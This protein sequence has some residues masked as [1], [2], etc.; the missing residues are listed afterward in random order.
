VRVLTPFL[1][2]F[3]GFLF[4]AMAAG[5]VSTAGILVQGTGQKLSI[6]WMAASYI[7]LTFGEVL[8]Y[9]TG[10]ELAYTAAPKNMKSFITACFLVTNALGN[11]VN[12]GASRLYGGSLVDSPDKRGP[13]SAGVF[14]VPGA[15]L[16]LAA[17][18]VFFFAC[19]KLGKHPEAEPAVSA[20]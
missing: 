5:I 18:F 7:I 2:I 4:T 13:L 15:L 6:W 20:E 10:L 16:A 3:L 19:R 14:F 11:L 12:I 17:G 9:G 1:K 8:L